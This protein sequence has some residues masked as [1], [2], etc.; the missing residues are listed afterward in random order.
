MFT[1]Y[2]VAKSKS[3][4]WDVEE[5]SSGPILLEASEKVII[6]NIPFKIQSES[7]RR[8]KFQKRGVGV[9]ELTHTVAGRFLPTI[10]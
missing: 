7:F 2:Y 1:C 10:E 9:S 6:I 8:G 5:R 3:W 4:Y